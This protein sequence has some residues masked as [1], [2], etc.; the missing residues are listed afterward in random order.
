MSKAEP[1]PPNPTASSPSAE[2][3]PVR[4]LRES[5]QLSKTAF[6]RELGCCPATVDRIEKKLNP[7]TKK[8]SDR[9][10]A[11][12]GVRIRPYRAKVRRVDGL[13]GKSAG[14][15]RE[16]RKSLN[17]TQLQLA[18]ALGM[19]QASIACMEQGRIRITE[20]TAAKIKELYGVEI[21]PGSEKK[22]PP[23]EE[24]ALRQLRESLG[25]TQLRFAEA[26]NLSLSTYSVYEREKKTVPRP[27]A[28]KIR[29]L[30]GVDLPE[31]MLTPTGRRTHAGPLR[32][33]DENNPVRKIR[34]A[35]RITREEMAEVIHV[36]PWLIADIE[37][38]T[39]TISAETARKIE[40][41]FGLEIPTR[42]P[43]ANYRYHRLR[44]GPIMD[45][46]SA[47]HIRLKGQ[48]VTLDKIWDLLGSVDSL[49]VALE[50][51][52]VYWR[53]K[54]STGFMELK[55]LLTPVSGLAVRGTDPGKEKQ[56]Q[57]QESPSGMDPAGQIRQLR[58]SLNMSK[59][60]FA[61]RIGIDTSYFRRIENGE[62]SLRPYI[63]DSIEREFGVRIRPQLNRFEQKV[64]A[65][66]A[67]KLRQKIDPVH[68]LRKGKEFALRSILNGTGEPD[69]LVISLDDMRAYWKKDGQEGYAELE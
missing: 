3:N 62:Y 53:L 4:Q 9:I 39:A 61:H 33:V 15:I 42:P 36:S 58:L 47:I 45:R 8:F 6:A 64:L 38:G 30:Y 52:I 21:R 29:N 68:I 11:Q 18:N 28:E 69:E 57:K 63:A 54:K 5:L 23:Q 25:M 34:V 32:P 50:E 7:L 13:K 41:A 40:D 12:Y 31:E 10:F 44:P 1:T 51:K 43:D 24:N 16:L 48:D 37:S 26:L 67:E 59:N 66:E 17:L 27:L 49:S 19:A 14:P 56:P 20:K 22:R 46:L 55:D 2:T 35:C 65:E 60:K